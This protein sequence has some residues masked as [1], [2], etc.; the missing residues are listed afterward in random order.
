MKFLTENPHVQQTLHN[1]LLSALED[2]PQDRSLTF[3]DM[4]SADKTPY[5]EA[6]VAEILRC[7]AV[8]PA[9]SKQGVRGLC[10]GNWTRN[11]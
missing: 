6:V 5:L 1:E 4:M 10:Y 7:G 8:A 11:A 9:S 2:A 3:D